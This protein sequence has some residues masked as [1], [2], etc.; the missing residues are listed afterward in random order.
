MRNDVFYHAQA[1][2]RLGGCKRGKFVFVLADG[3]GIEREAQTIEAYL[4]RIAAEYADSLTNT[5]LCLP[6][7]LG[8]SVR[9]KP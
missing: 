8:S 6:T 3:T 1:A 7:A 9:R 2:Y 5:F 4:T